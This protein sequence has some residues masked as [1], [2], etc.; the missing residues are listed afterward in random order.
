MLT[1]QDRMI[2]LDE[3]YAIEGTRWVNF[4]FQNTENLDRIDARV[5]DQADCAKTR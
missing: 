5:V 3:R 4:G 2:T 1:I